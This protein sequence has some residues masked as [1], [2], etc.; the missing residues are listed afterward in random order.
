MIIMAFLLRTFV[1]LCA[2][3]DLQGFKVARELMEDDDYV[4]TLRLH[5]EKSQSTVI[6]QSIVLNYV[7]LLYNVGQYSEALGF[8]DACNF[9]TSMDVSTLAIACCLKIGTLEALNA[10]AVYLGA[11]R[12]GKVGAGPGSG[13]YLSVGRIG[14][15]Y[16]LFAAK[17]GRYVSALE[18][19]QFV[20][21]AHLKNNLTIAIYCSMGRYREA[22]ILL[23]EL[24]RPIDQALT[25]RPIFS[26]EVVRSLADGAEQSADEELKR[27]VSA[28]YN[29]LDNLAEVSNATLEKM[30]L[31]PIYSP[32]DTAQPSST[33]RRGPPF[34]VIFLRLIIKHLLM[35]MIESYGPK[36]LQ[37]R[38]ESVFGHLRRYHSKG[39]NSDQQTKCPLKEVVYYSV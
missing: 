37:V 19:L 21:T 30:V 38:F 26:A 12:D 8:I 7:Q 24:T 31:A 27:K 15:I 36:R 11:F 9:D 17:H 20:R 10:A 14:C 6:A 32:S 3:C 16:A 18:E 4:N 35:P 22:V 1:Q 39:N 23:E 29:R 5:D 28:L 34:K 33:Q 25:R 2:Q 13:G